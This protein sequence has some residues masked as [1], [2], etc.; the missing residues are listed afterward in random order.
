MQCRPG[1]SATFDVVV[2]SAEPIR[3]SRIPLTRALGRLRALLAGPDAKPAP[4]MP[5]VPVGIPSE[6]DRFVI[7]SSASL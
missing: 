7:E 4:L 3:S 1:N 5:M 6:V 2:E